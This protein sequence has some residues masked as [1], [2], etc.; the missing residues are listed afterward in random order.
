MRLAPAPPKGDRLART[1]GEANRNT[2]QEGSVFDDNQGGEN[3]KGALVTGQRYS[4][5]SSSVAMGHYGKTPPRGMPWL[6][7]GSCLLE[8][9]L[10]WTLRGGPGLSIVV[11]PVTDDNGPLCSWSYLFVETRKSLAPASGPPSV[12]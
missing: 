9:Y 12:C 8:L 4:C 3:S 6:T 2:L 1:W 11:H 7:L 5:S 10:Y